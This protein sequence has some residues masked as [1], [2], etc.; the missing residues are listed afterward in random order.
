FMT[1]PRSS[2]EDDDDEQPESPSKSKPT[3]AKATPAK[4]PASAFGSTAFGST[5]FG[6]SFAS[7]ATAATS[8]SALASAAAGTKNGNEKKNPFGSTAFGDAGRTSFGGVGSGF[9]S[10]FGATASTSASAFGSV[11]SFAGFGNGTGTASKDA[12]V[13]PT[14]KPATLSPTKATPSSPSKSPVTTEKKPTTP[15]SSTPSAATT[16]AIPEALKAVSPTV[17]SVTFSGSLGGRDSEQISG[18]DALGS[19]STVKA[20]S[21]KS[22]EPTFGSKGS[23]STLTFGAFS[24]TSSS[25]FGNSSSKAGSSFEE[26]LK[27]SKPSAGTKEDDEDDAG[28]AD[29]DD[30]PTKF[31][32]PIEKK[33][34]I[35]EVEVKTGEEDESNIVQIRCKL[36]RKDEAGAWKERGIGNLKLNCDESSASARLVM[37]TE[38]AL[39]LILNSKVMPQ[40]PCKIVQEKFV[41]FLCAE[42]GSSASGEGEEKAGTTTQGEAKLTWFLAKTANAN[43]ATKLYNNIR[44]FSENE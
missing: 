14:P 22:S 34:D 26:L 24:S 33:T 11:S 16:A 30:D 20:V 2:N 41:Q 35:P 15:V 36:Y 21:F 7:P 9:G 32:V 1:V 13:S 44:V 39:R 25:A 37:R 42:S 18:K 28:G 43:L 3:T 5:A 31:E 4:P 6:S 8:F 17:S 29:D 10:P 23:S 38:G 40:M 19:N 12:K 27:S